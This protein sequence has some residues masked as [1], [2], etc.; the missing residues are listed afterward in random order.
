MKK[1]SGLD[2]YMKAVVKSS[3]YHQSH[4]PVPVAR[5]QRPLGRSPHHIF[6]GA[7]NLTEVWQIIAEEHEDHWNSSSGLELSATSLHC[8]MALNDC[9]SG[10]AG[11]RCCMFEVHGGSVR[12][13]H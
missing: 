9:R 10:L 2:Q 12:G 6:Q 13:S 1:P 3:A 8:Q 11:H 4:G 7:R 5:F